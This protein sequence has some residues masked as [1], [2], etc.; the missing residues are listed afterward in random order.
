MGEPFQLGRYALHAEL[1]AGGMAA[2]YLARQ[3]GAVGFGKT[4]AIKRAHPHLAKDPYFARMFLDEARLVARVQHPNVVPILDVVSTDSELFLV[5]EYVRGETLSGLL[6]AVRKK[7]QTIPVPIAAAIIVGLLT[8]LH[9]A[10]EARDE[11]GNPLNIV[12]R[13]VSPQNLMVGADGV[14]RVLD[15]GVA[16]AAS[17]LQTTREGQLKGKIPYMSPEQLQG[18]VTA[19]SDVYSSALV[20]WET[21]TAQRLFRGETEAQVLHLVMTMEAPPPSSINKDVPAALDAVVLKGLSRDPALRYATAREMAVAIEACVPIATPMKIAEWIDKLIGPTIA[22]RDAMRA[23]IE[24]G[25]TS[26]PSMPQPMTSPSLPGFPQVADSSVSIPNVPS[27]L[28]SIPNVA[29]NTPGVDGASTASLVV[30]TPQP[31]RPRSRLPLV[32]V[33]VAAVGALGIVLGVTFGRTHPQ[34]TQPAAT[35]APPTQTQAPAPIPS[36]SQAPSAAETQTAAPP[37]TPS[38]TTTTSHRRRPTTPHPSATATGSS[39]DINSLLD[40][41]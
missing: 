9:A 33:V 23:E 16:K 1:A 4:V 5:L 10:H 17:R 20:L 19:R 27:S 35:I 40:T 2:V 7:G 3:T 13:D 32:I 29:A 14:P 12:H 11:M 21:L 31:A 22:A 39:N 18:E 37:P 15:F 28:P 8:G 41:R 26:V 25:S 36:Q 24:S 34:A 30:V 38:A 6:R